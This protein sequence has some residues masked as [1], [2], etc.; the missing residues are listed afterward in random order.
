VNSKIEN[1]NMMPQ[2][3]HAKI[4]LEI[5][6]DYLSRYNIGIQITEIIACNNQP[7]NVDIAITY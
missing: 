2:V 1:I 3:N 4:K 5:K 6:K 7:T